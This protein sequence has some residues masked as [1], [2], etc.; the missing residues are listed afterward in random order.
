MS[1]P[2]IRHAPAPADKIDNDRALEL[3]AL[4]LDIVGNDPGL[5]YAAVDVIAERREAKAE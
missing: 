4:L 2:N 1:T 5:A 3:A